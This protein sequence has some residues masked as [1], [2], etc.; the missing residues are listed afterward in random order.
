MEKP[1]KKEL[2]IAAKNGDFKLIMSLIIKKG[3]R[4]DMNTFHK[5]SASHRVFNRIAWF[6]PGHTLSFCCN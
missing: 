2:D 4:A 5:T 6:V 3:I 1:F